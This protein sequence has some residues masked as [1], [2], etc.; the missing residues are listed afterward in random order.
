MTHRYLRPA[1]WIARLAGAAEQF[2][3]PSV[4]T[5]LVARSAWRGGEPDL[6]RLPEWIRPGAT[7]LDAGANRGV[8]AW[9]MR[10][11][12]GRVHAFEPN[13]ELAARLRRAM[14]D[15]T[16]HAVALSDVRGETELRLP[17]V[18]GVVY[19]GWATVE[20]DNRFAALPAEGERRVRVPLCR[21]DDLGFAE[22]AFVKI[23]VEG[24][25]LAVLRGAEVTL[26]RC[27]PV[28]L[29][30]ADDRHRP[31]TVA[32]CREF[33][34]GLGYGMEPAA[35]PGMWFSASIQ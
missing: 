29:F 32:A 12:G 22:V 2:L 8:W 10:R 26:R 20:C 35:T 9:H 25:E 1:W 23:D 18:A 33:L 28:I 17:V 3:P 14:P 24:H 7:A 4:T 34:A 15:V 27:R 21:L 30:E 31:G 5:A 13:P 6:R 16:V 11:L 19:E